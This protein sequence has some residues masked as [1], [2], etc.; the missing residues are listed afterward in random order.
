MDSRELYS[1]RAG[2]GAQDR[3]SSSRGK[4]CLQMHTWPLPENQIPGDTADVAPTAMHTAA[5][6]SYVEAP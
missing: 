3:C 1:A 6:P 5:K 2:D 4:P